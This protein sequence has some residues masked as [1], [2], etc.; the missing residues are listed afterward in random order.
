[1]FAYLP[2]KIAL[3]PAILAFLLAFIR[4]STSKIS[5]SHQQQVAILPADAR[6]STFF[7]FCNATDSKA[8]K[9]E[10]AAANRF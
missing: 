1:M 10:N 9:R 3:L 6:S 2:A 4:I 5:L 7:L 8:N